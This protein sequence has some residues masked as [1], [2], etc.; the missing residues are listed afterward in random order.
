MWQTR[1]N[2]QLGK[3][4]DSITARTQIGRSNGFERFE[5]GLFNLTGVLT[6]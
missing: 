2:L 5:A 4:D 1:K 6:C 3:T